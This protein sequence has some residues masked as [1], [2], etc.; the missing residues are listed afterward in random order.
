[1]ERI[2]LQPPEIVK[3][4]P[5]FIFLAGPIQ[6]APN[7]QSEAVSIIHNINPSVIIASPR[8]EYLNDSFVYEKQVDWETHYLRL[9]SQIGVIAFW[10]AAQTEETP[11][12]AYAQTSR[13]E[14][15]EWKVHHQFFGTV[16]S[17]GIEKGFGNSRYIKHRFNQDCPKVKI[18]SNLESM[19][20]N[21]ID[22]AVSRTA[23]SQRT[24]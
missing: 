7:W 20:Q 8:K 1:M 4:Q 13:L 6:G 18:S 22:L 11:G 5:P 17:V 12:R 24:T 9:A 2:V 16:L 3:A 21:A 23:Q 19:C 10:L 14:L 15:G